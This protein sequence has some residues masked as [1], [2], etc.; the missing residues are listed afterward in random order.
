MTA[1]NVAVLILALI[2]F[3]S[4]QAADFHFDG[5]A[6]LR[7]VAPPTDGSATYGDLG[8]LRYGYDDGSVAA[9]IGDIVG[10]ARAQ[11]VPELMAVAVGRINAQY[12]PAVDLIE[13]YLRYRPVSTSAW[14]WSVK[15]GAFFPP[16]SLEND[17]IGWTSAWTITPSAINSWIGY[18][19]RTIGAEGRIEWRRDDGTLAL[20][21]A[22]FG[23]NDPAGVLIA[24]RG[25]SFD[26][27][28]SGI[29]EHERLPDAVAISQ[30]KTSP[31]QAELFRELDNTPG[32]YLNLSWD[33]ADIGSFQIMRYDNDADPKVQSGGQFAWH[34]NFWNAGF[35]KQIENVTLLAQAMTGS[36]KIQ[37]SPTFYTAT[38]FSSA[39][40]L[41]G[42]D[43]D[44]WRLAARV[45]LFRT[46]THATFPSPASENGS[47]GTLAATW[48][49]RSWLQFTG[50]LIVVDSTRL[51]RLI[52]NDP[53]HVTERQLQLMARLF[54]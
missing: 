26:D 33:P 32:W 52:V 18:E 5:Y 12:G 21:G 6:D 28:V 43:L 34:T 38:N 50:E 22:L 19:L 10:E 16:G 29:F 35:S 9:K 37:P 51:Q 47:S 31:V 39:Y 45:D 3:G 54:Y 42:I 15:L 49:A 4:A 48:F 27:R 24:D 30:H 11:I 14:R 13:A 23:W 40:V 8:K 2:W 25:W 36:T 41:A 44:P 1:R 20:T 46:Q 17:Q 53:A 7:L